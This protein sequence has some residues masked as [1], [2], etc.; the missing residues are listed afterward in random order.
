M[1]FFILKKMQISVSSQT[2][3]LNASNFFVF[4]LYDSSAPSVLLESQQ[5]AKP[6]GNPIQISF[7]YN[8]LSGH[9][10]IIKLWESPDNTPT[11]IVRNSFSQA[12][13]SNA[14]S[15]S[16]KLDEYLE[17]DVTAGLVSGTTSYVNTDWAGW[18]YSIERI[19]AGTMVPDSSID[20][21]PNYTQTPTGGFTLKQSGDV[22]QPDEKFVVRFTPQVFSVPETGAP[23]SIFSSG[24]VI[25]SDETLTI[26]DL[27]KALLIQ[28]ASTTIALVL[29]SLISVADYSFV[30][31]YSIGGSHYNAV[32]NCPGTDKIKYG[33][34]DNVLSQI[35]LGQVEI[36]KLFKA[37]NKWNVENELIGVKCV[38]EVFYNYLGAEINALPF[39][40]QLV[41]RAEYPRFWAYVQTLQTG[42]VVTDSAWNS[43]FT[44]VDGINYYTLK[45]CFSAGDGSTNFRLPLI[46]NF[47]RPISS[48]VPG[49]LELQTIQAHDHHIT[50]SSQTNFG[51]FGHVPGVNLAG[52]EDGGYTDNTGDAETKPTNI[53][54]PLM[55]RI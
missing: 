8:C 44:T 25:T 20:T 2:S 41:L 15:V 19:G 21:D 37:N 17:A 22:F 53:G 47:I 27:N 48:R 42:S 14:S 52:T 29:P 12:V 10:Y 24:R 31:I 45:G 33:F 51:G 54:L 32:I 3:L 23:S 40:G 11:G 39:S 18:N 5:P 30:Y 9:I 36:L 35:I 43:T 13:N 38:G 26:S 28:S 7:T 49:S 50:G 55:I 6:Y 1:A 16:V 34:F 46:T 4:A